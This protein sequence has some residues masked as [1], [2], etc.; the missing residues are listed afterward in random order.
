MPDDLKM[1][2]NLL[3]PLENYKKQWVQT[4]PNDIFGPLIDISLKYVIFIRSFS[5]SFDL[6]NVPREF[7]HIGSELKPQN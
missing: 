3:K 1:L 2:E 5:A 4:E 7:L 6:E